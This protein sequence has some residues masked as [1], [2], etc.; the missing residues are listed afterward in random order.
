MACYVLGCADQTVLCTDH[1][2]FGMVESCEG[3]EPSRHGYGLSRVAG[4]Q[5]ALSSPPA[6]PSDPTG[7]ANALIVEVLR[8][9]LQALL[10]PQGPP[11]GGWRAR[12]TPPLPQPPT[13]SHVR[14]F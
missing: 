5:V 12:L 8:N 3:H 4:P 11:E 7:D 6:P 9:A 1:K 10:G 14:P 13:G 2:T